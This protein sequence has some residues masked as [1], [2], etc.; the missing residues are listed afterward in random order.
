M[1]IEIILFILGLTLGFSFERAW[2]FSEPWRR[3]RRFWYVL[4]VSRRHARQTIS[5]RPSLEVLMSG[6]SRQKSKRAYTHTAEVVALQ[7][8]DNILRGLPLNVD[9]DYHQKMDTRKG[10]WILL[11][12]GARTLNP[13]SNRVLA[14]IR[15]RPD[16]FLVTPEGECESF[17]DAMGVRYE[18]NHVPDSTFGTRVTQDYGVI[19][20]RIDE[21]GDICLL[22]GGIHMHGTQAAAHVAFSHEF[23]AKVRGFHQYLQLV[24]VRIEDDGLTISAPTWKSLPFICIERE[25]TWIERIRSQTMGRRKRQ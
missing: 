5:I 3:L 25:P 9:F 2:E 22:C 24:K 7:E 18:C 21:N 6:Q 4:P 8:L 23:R 1:G 19:Y 20:R 14:E 16:L 12:T 11:G 13:L 17:Q 10:N 15:S